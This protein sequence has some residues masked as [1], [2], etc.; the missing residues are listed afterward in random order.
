MPI[1]P[2]DRLELTYQRAIVD[3][4]EEIF[5]APYPSWY[6][7]INH[8]PLPE[9][10]TYC[11]LEFDAQVNNGGLHQY[12]WNGYG[13]F[14]YETVAYLC[15]LGAT[16][17]AGILRQALTL[18]EA[19]EPVPDLLRE[20]VDSRTLLALNDFVEPLTSGLDALSDA[21]YECAMDMKDRIQQFLAN[22]GQALLGDGQV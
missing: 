16:T 21:Y 19:E 5:T 2:P 12:F 20:K 3:L 1:P 7:H 15:L 14:G 17:Q 4:T 9:R 8:L 22:T 11:V 10:L 13:Q 6:A 18:L